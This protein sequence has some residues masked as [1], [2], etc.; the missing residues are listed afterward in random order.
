[1]RFQDW[2]CNSRNYT[3]IGQFIRARYAPERKYILSAAKMLVE[4]VREDGH[5]SACYYTWH[6]KDEIKELL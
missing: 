6:N 3:D 4:F 2:I 1:M 5:F